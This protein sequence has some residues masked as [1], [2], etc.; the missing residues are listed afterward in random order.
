MRCLQQIEQRG[1]VAESF[2]P[3]RSEVPRLRCKAVHRDR[4]P[5]GRRLVPQRAVGPLVV[6]RVEEVRERGGA[7]FVAGI[8]W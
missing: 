2:Y 4:H 7:L 3:E 8:W 5:T 1:L 6:V